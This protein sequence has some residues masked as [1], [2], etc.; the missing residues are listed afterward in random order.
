M[1]SSTA[2]NR[3]RDYH[4]GSG[5]RLIKKIENTL[6]SYLKGNFLLFIIIVIV[7]L[8]G[9][10]L[11]SISIKTLNNLQKDNLIEYINLFFQKV[12]IDTI[13]NNVVLKHSIINNIKFIFIIWVLGL[14]II[15][16]PF[17]MLLIFIKGFTIGF[18]VGFIVDELGFKGIIFSTISLLPQN[19]IIV[20]SFIIIGVTA[21]SF[22]ILLLKSRNSL[23]KFSLLQQIAGYTVLIFIILL[24][25]IVGCFVEAYISPVFM[26]F[27]LPYI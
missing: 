5:D 6:F 14:T 8:V 10:V 19:I 24:I 25:V 2:Y 3:V 13:N 22:S 7:L 26:K 9:I 12:N 27:M 23:E 15:G 4:R 1:P 20:P 17:I 16:I 11:G 21:I 18:T